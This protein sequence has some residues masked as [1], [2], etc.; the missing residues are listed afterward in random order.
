M[1]HKLK[2]QIRNWLHCS[3]NFV[4]PNH[5]DSI[6]TYD[7]VCNHDDGHMCSCRVEKLIELV[8]EFENTV[9]K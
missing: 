8:E 7:H 3:G 4:R 9:D 6:M 5:Q 2:D 1:T